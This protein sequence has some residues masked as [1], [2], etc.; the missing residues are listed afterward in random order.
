MKLSDAVRDAIRRSGQSIY[1]I[2][3][4]T[5]VAEWSLSKFVRGE[6]GLNMKALDR[7]ADHFGLTIS[8]PSGT[9][10]GEAK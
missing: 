5:Q 9:K 7:L 8:S 6:V 2:A 4:Q 10:D 1:K 3:Y